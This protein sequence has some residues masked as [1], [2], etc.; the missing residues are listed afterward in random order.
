VRVVHDGIDLKVH[1]GG[2]RPA[3]GVENIQVL[4]AHRTQP[5]SADGF[6]WTYNHAPMLAYAHGRFYL[7]Y[8]SNPFGEHVPPGQTLL[9]TSPDGRQWH[10]PRQVFP[11]YLLRPGPIYG[12]APSPTGVNGIGRVVREVYADASFG[13][14]HF[15]RYNAAAGRTEANTPRFPFYARSPDQEFVAACDALLADQLKTMQWREEDRSDDGFYTTPGSV[16][17]APSVFHRKDGVAVA[18][19]KHSWSA[20]PMTT[21]ARGASQCRC[22]A[23]SPGARRPGGNGL[24]TV[25]MRWS[26]IRPSAAVGRSR[27]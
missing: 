22:R 25:A 2:L 6:G 1:D 19:W 11:I 9:V 16:L 26:T 17:Q 4:R 21:G 18:L 27:W 14:I 15:I 8:L 24:P 20:L 7:Q 13:P 5:E 3:I 23:S 10:R 12:H